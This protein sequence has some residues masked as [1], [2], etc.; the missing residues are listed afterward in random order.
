MQTAATVVAL[1]GSQQGAW[2]RTSRSLAACHLQ[3]F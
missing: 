1:L 3:H 2:R